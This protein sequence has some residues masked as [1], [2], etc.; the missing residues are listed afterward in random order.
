MNRPHPRPLSKLFHP[1]TVIVGGVHVRKNRA[2]L[3]PAPTWQTI[4]SLGDR[5]KLWRRAFQR[6]RFPLSA[7]ERGA[8]NEVNVSHS[9]W[10]LRVLSVLVT[11]IIPILLVLISIRLLTTETYLRL[12][13]TKPDFPPDTYGFTLT[14]R[15]HYGPYAVRYLTTNNEIGYLASVTFPDGTPLFN[16]RELGHMV[17]VKRV[18]QAAFA[19]LGLTVFLFGVL[20]VMLSRSSEGRNALRQ[21]LFGGGLLM[22]VI[23]FGL[24][25]YVLL[26][27]D[28]F[29]TRFHQLFFTG[30]SWLFQYSDSL[31]RLYPIRFWQDAA[32]TIAALCALG[33]VLSMVGAWWWSKRAA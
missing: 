15:L 20:I 11:L 26:Q 21:G 32:L 24:L 8:G 9:P 14:D 7:S 28:Q 17:D 3:R 22:L 2:G 19:A 4:E 6:G 10:L 13:Y 30:D 33:G 29:F 12:E 18:M 31:I 1:L 23:L 25:L 27:W 5:S 16:E